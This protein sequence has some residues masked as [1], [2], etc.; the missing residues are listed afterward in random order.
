MTAGEKIEKLCSER[1]VSPYKLFKAINKTPSSVYGILRQKTINSNT[2]RLIADY[3]KVD[4]ST[5]LSDSDDVPIFNTAIYGHKNTTNIVGSA[6]VSMPNE[7]IEEL[8]KKI[9]DLQNSIVVKDILI[10]SLRSEISNKEEL[11]KAKDQLIEL[12]RR[13]FEGK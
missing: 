3:F 13:S 10:D 12:L 8:N 9:M 6:S 2:L 7:D 11:I 4:V 5:L 1:G